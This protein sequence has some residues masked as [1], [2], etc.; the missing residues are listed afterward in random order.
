MMICLA[1]IRLYN[2]GKAN[3]PATRPGKVWRTT[4]RNWALPIGASK[5]LWL[6]VSRRNGEAGLPKGNESIRWIFIPP[7]II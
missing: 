3:W 7:G 2:I 1:K 6:I 5:A 4:A